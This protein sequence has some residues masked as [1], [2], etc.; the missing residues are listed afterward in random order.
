[1]CMYICLYI[2]IYIT[3]THIYV[4]IYIY[5]YTYIYINIYLYIY[6]FI[7]TYIT[8]QEASGSRALTVIA[9]FELHLYLIIVSIKYIYISSRIRV[10]QRQ[11][12]VCCSAISCVGSPHYNTLQHT[13]NHC[14]TLRY[15]TR[16]FDVYIL[17]GVWVGVFERFVLVCHY[18]IVSLCDCSCM[19][20]CNSVCWCF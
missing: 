20:L 10:L 13:A 1:M 6:I 9:L 4:H 8:T 18:V 15:N 17:M 14:K 12:F 3:Y 19:S 16:I 2:H 11:G 7:P 5:T